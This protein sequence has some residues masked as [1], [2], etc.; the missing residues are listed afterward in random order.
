VTIAGS[1]RI[2]E[3]A[4]TALF[5]GEIVV[6]KNSPYQRIVLTKRGHETAM[7]LNGNLQFSSR[8]EYRYHEALVHPAMATAARTQ[9][10]LIGGGGDGLAVREVLKWP[11]VRSVTVVDLD[12]SVTDLGKHHPQLVLLNERALAD[13]RV[14][15][16]NDDAMTEFE[17]LS[18]KFDVVLLDFPDPSSYS[19]GK[20]Y[21]TRFYRIVRSKLSAGGALAVQ[22]TSPLFARRAFWCVVSTIESVGLHALPY[23]AFVPSFGDWGYVLAKS[24]PISP[25]TEL[26]P[27][28]LSYLDDRNLRSLFALPADLGRVPTAVNQLNTQALVSYYLEDWGRFN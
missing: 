26:P 15:I 3:F 28:K 11:E 22:S 18:G 7:Y 10:V 27:L 19:L 1:A 4:E 12:R 14:T 9:R 6:A 5:G 17:R 25:P 8:D 21:S 13:E 24:E 20:L 2:A 16:I 23:H